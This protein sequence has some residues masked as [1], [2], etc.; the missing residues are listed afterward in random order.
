M[1]N[2][3]RSGPALTSSPRR[4]SWPDMSAAL[5]VDVMPCSNEEYFPPPPSKQQLQ[6]MWLADRETERLRR[7]FNMSRREFVRT[8]AATAIGF[9]A[10]DMV[11]PGLFG[12]YG[13]ARAGVDACDLEFAGGRG[14]ES[15]RNLPGE[16]IFDVQSHHV[17]PD[18]MW[19]VTNP[20]IHA[21]YAAVWPQA[22]PVFGESGGELDPIANLSRFHYLKELFLDSATTMT[23]LSC[24]PTSPDADNPLP[25]AE[26]ALTVDTV[27]DLA[28][29]RRSVMH[30]FVMPNR[31]SPGGDNTPYITPKYL[32]EELDLMM[33]RA[34]IY[35]TKLRGWKTYCAWGSVPGASG[36][37]LDS[38]TGMAFLEQVREISH[39]FKKVPP[40]VA[41][42]KGFALPG[43]D[44]EKSTPRDIGPAAKANRDIR[45]LVYHSGYDIGDTQRAYA[46]DANVRSNTNHVDA[47]VKSLRE[48]DYDA[49]RFRKRGKRFGNVPNVYAEL[50][51]VWRS[52]M[53][54]PD[55]AAHLLGKLITHVGPKRI[56]WGTDSLWYGSPQPEIVAMRRFEFTEQGKELYRLPH[57]LEGDVNDPT[58]KAPRPERTIRNAILGR[59]AARAYRIDP[60]ARRKKIHCDDVS[61]LRDGG[62]L[63]GEPG[64]LRESAPLASHQA[65]GPRTRR[66]VVK[67][68]RENP[69]AP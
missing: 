65:P 20:V 45:F 68:L 40:V 9:W 22:N 6:I 37:W 59:N 7:K 58:R 43:F 19:R 30:S 1:I 50:G 69:W 42:H 12:S 49:T 36:W 2:W 15:L 47:L 56:C 60:D 29:T 28:D 23:V 67:A 46:G 39:R 66:E 44:Q 61:A 52:V 5:P 35:R 10:I 63:R 3:K 25:L 38:D 4:H 32:Q 53:D 11:R 24:S 21:F 34:S 8:A 51:S 57:G 55:Q 64:S 14:L 54:D 62:Y 17:D 31:G 26:A 18:G 48:N 27:N 16:F 13:A 41:T 33:E